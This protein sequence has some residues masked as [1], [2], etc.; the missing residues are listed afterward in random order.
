MT[1]QQTIPIDT[2]A[3]LLDAENGEQVL[4]MLKTAG[5]KEP[6]IQPEEG[7][8]Q[9]ITYDEA[10]TLFLKLYL[11]NVLKLKSDDLNH[12]IAQNDITYNNRAD[13]V[14]VLEDEILSV[15]IRLKK[16]RATFIDWIEKAPK[17]EPPVPPQG[18]PA[19]E[20]E[21]TLE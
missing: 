17:L 19:E 9:L 18:P 3:Y 20:T 12:L 13:V 2:L 15:K 10:F 7:A 14:R 8:P 11:G 1:T 16:A 21:E 6:S 5:I 4:R